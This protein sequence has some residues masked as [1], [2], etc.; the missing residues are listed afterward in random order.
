MICKA[1]E[2]KQSNS[3]D[4]LMAGHTF[5]ICAVDTITD[6]IKE[7]TNIGSIWRKMYI[8]RSIDIT[9]LIVW[10]DQW[11]KFFIIEPPVHRY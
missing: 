5:K 6:T 1:I 4:C 3:W 9:T 10:A 11:V 7:T 8:K 2:K